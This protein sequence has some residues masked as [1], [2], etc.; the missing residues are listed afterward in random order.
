M[1]TVRYTLI[2]LLSFV[3]LFALQSLAISNIGWKTT[4]C[5]SNFYS[6]IGRIQS[7]I[8]GQPKMMLLG[9]SLTGRLPDR[10]QGFDGVTNL[11]CDGGSAADVLRAMDTGRLPTAPCLIIE[12]NTF[13]RAVANPVSE[14]HQAIHSPWFRAGTLLPQVSAS[15]RPSAF[16]YSMMLARKIGQAHGPDG[17]MLPNP[18]EPTT[19]IQKASLPTDAAAFI[20]EMQSILAHLQSRN[21]RMMLVILPPGADGESLNMRVPRELSRV[22]GV[23]LLD[24]TKGLPAGSVRYTD[25][26]HMDPA[27]AAAAL[28]TILNA[29]ER[30]Q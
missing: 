9:S 2:L 14:I 4:K 16:L 22:S 28:R 20:E 18:A 7:G 8:Q 6:S 19:E 30:S 27:S 17:Q 12:G 21:V 13:Y 25:G 24:L 1:D 5:E 23:P 3:A 29:L 26:V 11:G 15:A 10:R